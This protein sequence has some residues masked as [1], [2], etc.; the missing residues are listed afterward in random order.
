MNSKVTVQREGG[1]AL[2]KLQLL[3]MQLGL[4][5]DK[6]LKLIIDDYL[7]KNEMKITISENIKDYKQ[8]LK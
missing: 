1:R 8:R 3:C 5:F 4:D 6:T 2:M 7:K